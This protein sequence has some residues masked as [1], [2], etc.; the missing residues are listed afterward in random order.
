[1]GLA[2]GQRGG[3]LRPG[4]RGGGL[5]P[6]LGGGG[7]LVAGAGAGAGTQGGPGRP[8]VQQR[9]R[10]SSRRLGSRGCGMPGQEEEVGQH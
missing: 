3:G 7:Y 2:G 8:R 9:D 6:A 5:R 1:M 4:G 10:Q